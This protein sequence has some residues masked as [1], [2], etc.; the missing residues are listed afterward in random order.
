MGR[1][2]SLP[3]LEAADPAHLLTVV[4]HRAVLPPRIGLADQAVEAQR[5][6]SARLNDR[7]FDRGLIVPSMGRDPRAWQARSLRQ[8]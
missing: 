7:S 6:A 3:V 4:R 2:R 8:A 1:G 5:A